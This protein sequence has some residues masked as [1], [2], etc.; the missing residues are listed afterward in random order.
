MATQ[1]PI[2]QEGTYP[3]PEAQQDRF[4]FSVVM[5]YLNED[6][7]VTAVQRSSS[8][9]SVQL[10]VVLKGEELL[11]YQQQ[12]RNVQVPQQLSEYIVDLVA[13]SRPG[14]TVPDFINEYVAWGAGLRASQY[15]ALGA[16]SRAALNGRTVANIEDV[17]TVLVP[18]MR[19]RIG[20]NFRAEV[21]KVK[22][23]D[24][25]ARLVAH[26]PAPGQGGK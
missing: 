22:V 3:L 7:E 11:A 9:G 13:A 15:I 5:T 21:D 17:R 4:M 14:K 24:I 8:G 16:K 1:N 18:V 10:K 20:L 12:I 25:I 2:E 26:Q 23:E 19:H 6:E